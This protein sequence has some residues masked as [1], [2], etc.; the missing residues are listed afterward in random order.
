MNKVL[1]IIQFNKGDSCLNN[2]T[3]QITDILEQHNPHIAIINELNND[4]NDSVTR[5]SFQ[6]YTLE[7]DN[8][9]IY[10]KKSRTGI[11]IKNN[12]HYKR[13]IDLE[14]PGTSTLWIQLSHPGKK[15]ILIQGIYRQFQRLGKDHTK[16]IANQ[17][18]RWEQI[19]SKW[20]IASLENKE[21]ISMGDTNLNTLRWETPIEEK[22]S[23]E[24][25]QIN[26]V[27][28]FQDRILNKG[29]KILNNTP[30]R[31]KDNIESKP[32]CLDLIM[33]NKIDKIANFQSG[34][35]NF[36]DHTLQILE[37]KAK[38]VEQKPKFL[39]IRSYK[40]F[41][42]TQ[43][44]ENIINHPY[45]IEIFY[46]RDPEIITKKLQKI[47][48]QSIDPLAP[49]KT[50][51]VSHKNSNKLSTQV[52]EMMIQRDIAYEK[53]KK[54][55]N[56][57]DIRYYKNLKNGVNQKI[58]KEKFDRKVAIFQEQGQ[59]SNS[60]W[61]KIKNETSQNKYTNPQSITEGKTTFT[62]HHQIAESLNRQYVR[63]INKIIEQMKSTP[64]NPLDHFIHSIG[65]TQGD[66]EF[67]FQQINMEELKKII[68]KL[69]PTGSTGLDEISIKMIK[70][71][72]DQLQPILLH[73]INS[74]IKSTTFPEVLKVSKIVPI[75]KAGKDPTSADAWRP[76]NVI[77]A[78]AKI[79]ERV[80]LAQILKHLDQ[81]NLIGHSHHGAVRHKSTQSLVNE[82]HDTLLEDFMKDIDN[83]IIAL[84]QSKAYDIVDHRILLLKLQAIGFK[85][86]AIKIIQSYL[87]NRTQYVALEGKKSQTLAVGPR[88]VIQ[89]SCLSTIMFLIYTL[90]LPELFHRD[91]D[92][93]HSPA[94]MRLCSKTNAKGFVDDIYLKVKPTENQDM[95]TAI[96][97]TMDTIQDYMLANKL[98]LNPQKSQIMI[99]TKKE[100]IKE[101]FE[102]ILNGK[103]VKNKQQIVILG[104]T[105]A[106]NLSWDTHVQ[107]SLIPAL[108]NRVRSLKLIAK[109]L[110]PGFRAQYTNAV[111]RSKLMFA[112]EAWGGAS[113]TL[114]QKVQNLQNQAAKLALPNNKYNLNSRQKHNLLNWHSIQTEIEIATHKFTWKII[115]YNIP[116]EL[117]AQ[118][119]LNTTGK[120]DNTTK[121]TSQ[122]TQM[123]RNNK[124]IQK[125]LQE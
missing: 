82:L 70:Q 75:K 100:H 79:I 52:K 123:A 11:L 104:N 54:T 71:A 92:T 55:K 107:K 94:E 93:K 42:K 89:G 36:S 17:E 38:I 5:H 88:S 109:Y 27:K 59:S 8:L 40:N 50:I 90:D 34:L 7:T 29:F 99:I 45:Y 111:F 124:I 4:K 66:L 32:A 41:K 69:K 114:I 18:W 60:I 63:S 96:M 81:H 35:S 95:K 118:M 101:N 77:Q 43:F 64:T 80:Y 51:Q 9:E 28:N 23:Y 13:R 44:R 21:I 83:A 72:Q 16:S 58:A 15:P 120:K 62:K 1:K 14:T 116:E 39:R 3:D 87:A 76:I 115:N 56:I 122:Q 125:F 110:K 73:L 61:K 12:I 31:Q 49:M 47:I 22:T 2:R 113:K 78:I 67:T 97:D 103:P 121:K 105:L 30:T 74:T 6:N 98:Q 33:T 19:L 102:V 25:S 48:Q 84:D 85:P 26:M 112:I 37:R 91:C 119:P 86:Q 53:S 108:T 24:K 46:E 10:D 106:A 65:P 117:A 20:E 68:S 57:E